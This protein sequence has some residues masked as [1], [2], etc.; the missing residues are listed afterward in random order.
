MNISELENKENEIDC[1]DSSSNNNN[2]EETLRQLNEYLNKFI[3]M[4]PNLKQIDQREKVK[5]ILFSIQ[6]SSKRNDDNNSVNNIN[7][8]DQLDSFK[9]LEITPSTKSSSLSE[10]Q[11]LQSVLDYILELKCSLHD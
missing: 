3:E 11:I 2:Q 10:L 7:D 8:Q 4:V 9:N 5:R 1:V 6:T